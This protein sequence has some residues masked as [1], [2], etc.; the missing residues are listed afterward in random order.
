ML[1]WYFNPRSREGSDDGQTK[2]DAYNNAFQSTLPRRERRKL[3]CCWCNHFR[4]QSTLPRRER[5]TRWKR[6]FVRFIFQSTLP[7]RERH[8]RFNLFSMFPIISIHAPAKGA[9]AFSIV[10]VS[11]L[12]LFQSTLPRRERPE[13]LADTFYIWIF[14]STLPRRERLAEQE[15]LKADL[16]NFNPRSREGSDIDNDVL[17]NIWRTLFQST[18]PRRERLRGS[19]YGKCKDYFNPRSREGSDWK[20]ALN[21]YYYYI[22]IH[23]PAKGATK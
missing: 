15:L 13:Q 4:F 7:R 6:F 18:L 3:C 21:G 10:S 17:N 1:L 19:G 8:H 12:A 14:Q 2:D 23:A 5:R 11:S 9:T 20:R 16:E 22:S